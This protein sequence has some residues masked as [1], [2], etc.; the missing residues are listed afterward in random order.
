VHRLEFSRP[1]PLYFWVYFVGFN[2]PW[3]VVPIGKIPFRPS[4]PEEKNAANGVIVLL[5]S[6][7]RTISR[8]LEAL[9]KVDFIIKKMG[10]KEGNEAKT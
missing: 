2:I 9:E 1:E 3:F 4:D 7:T 8:A 10:A 5:I 6:S